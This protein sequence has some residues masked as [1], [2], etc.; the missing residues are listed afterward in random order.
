MKR[1]SN[2][3]LYDTFT[4]K[5]I[6]D[7]SANVGTQTLYAT[8]NKNF[9]TIEEENKLVPKTQQE[10]LD[11]V[12]NHKDQLTDLRLSNIMQIYFGICTKKPDVLKNSIVIA[13]H[14]NESLHLSKPSQ[15]LYLVKDGTPKLIRQYEA[16]QW[17]ESI[18]DTLSDSEISKIIS[19]HFPTIKRA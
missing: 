2:N 13:K 1:I 15:F 7:V 16:I 14:Q 4:A 12:Q 11:I 17:I 9:F 10:A 18:Q 19:N 5:R 8:P 6:L 3:V